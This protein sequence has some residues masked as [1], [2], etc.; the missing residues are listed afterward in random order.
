MAL[1]K[2][3]LLRILHQNMCG[4]FTKAH[5]VSINKE[6]KVKIVIRR[7]HLPVLFNSI[8]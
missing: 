3:V 4:C 2:D 8:S 1:T 7:G 6:D 5:M